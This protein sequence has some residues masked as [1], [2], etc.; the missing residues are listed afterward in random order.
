[1]GHHINI[2]FKFSDDCYTILHLRRSKLYSHDIIEIVNSSNCCSV[3]CLIQEFI[4]E[5]Y[6]IMCYF[7]GQYP[8]GCGENVE[9]KSCDGKI[10]AV[11]CTDDDLY[12]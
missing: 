10:V 2:K 1:M 3:G 6:S 11:K 12:E 9:I 5:K 7:G 4:K 8:L